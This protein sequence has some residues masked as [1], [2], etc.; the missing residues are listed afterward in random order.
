MEIK[1]KLCTDRQTDRQS[2]IELLKIIA[3]I[4]IVISHVVQTL[5]SPNLEIFYQEY[6][7]DISKATTDIQKIVLVIFRHFGTWGN[8]LFFI[9]SAWF[10]LKSSAYKKKKWFHMLVEIWL[11]SIIIMIMSY[12]LLAGNISPKMVIKSIFPTLFANN[13][14][15]TCYLLFYPIHPILNDIIKHMSQR[16]LFRSMSALAILYIFLDF[17]KSNWFFPSSLILWV[18]IYFV[19]AYMQKYLMSYADNVKLNIIVMFLN[20]IGFVG[21]ILLTEMIGL[22]IS[23]LN[24]K[25]MHWAN[26]CNPFLIFM[27]ISMFNIARNIQFKNRLINWISSLSLL[28]YI[29][30]ENLILRTYFRPAMWNYVYNN[31]GYEHVV[32]WVF[33][34]MIIVFLFGTI[35]A[36]AYRIILNRPVKAASDKLYSV[37][38]KTYLAIEKKI[39]TNI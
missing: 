3:I 35:G 13:W 19:I 16:Q 20:M 29:I 26:G 9:C 24:D 37:L 22:H 23:F 36:A 39:L 31:F 1:T 38:R 25:M 18:T 11:V 10:L 6:V 27:S 12:G 2:G 30:H 21:I 28:I 7:I 5:T 34:L 15:M 8:S 17:I 33:V 32:M 14:Y 4:L